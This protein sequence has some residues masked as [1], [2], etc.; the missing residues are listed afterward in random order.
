MYRR[1]AG[2]IF[3]K[4]RFSVLNIFAC[5]LGAKAKTST[6]LRV[7]KIFVQVSH[8]TVFACNSKES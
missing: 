7:S 1:E 2:K 4:R 5:F 3:V 8:A 6:L